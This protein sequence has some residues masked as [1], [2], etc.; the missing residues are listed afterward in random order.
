MDLDWPDILRGALSFFLIIVGVGIA[1]ACLRLGGLFGR[2]STSVTRMTDEVVP[3]LSK[4]QT[5][6]D[7]I[8]TEIS[9]VDEIMQSAVATTKG[10]EKAVA[11]VSRAV[12]APA[13]KLSGLA[14][15]VQEAMATFKARRAAEKV[16]EEPPDPP[17]PDVSSE[18]EGLS[19]KVSPYPGK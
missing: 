5:T 19:P 3:I 13:K 8:N 17:P 18:G 6:M 10:A 7:G 16:T 2:V 9:R 11:S 4:A 15:G 14:A 1:W 12:T